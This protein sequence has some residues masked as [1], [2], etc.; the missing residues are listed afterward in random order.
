MA[1]EAGEQIGIHL[2]H[3]V[4]SEITQD[5]LTSFHNAGLEG[6][7]S[8]QTLQNILNGNGTGP[9]TIQLVNPPKAT[10]LKRNILYRK[11]GYYVTDITNS[12][13]EQFEDGNFWYLIGRN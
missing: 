12:I 7:T 6:I 13:L 2:V 9:M 10:L 8:K 5:S 1:I 11:F 4:L 3:H